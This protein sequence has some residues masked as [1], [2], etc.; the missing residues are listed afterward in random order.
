VSTP[1]MPPSEVLGHY[2]R[3]RPNVVVYVRH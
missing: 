1:R 2:P 3:G